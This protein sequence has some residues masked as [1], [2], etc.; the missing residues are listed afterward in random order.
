MGFNYK[1]HRERFNPERVDKL[2]AG[3]WM[4]ISD[5]INYTGFSD[6]TLRKHAFIGKLE[7]VVYRKFL[8][9]KVNGK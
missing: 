9:V 1:W 7:A 3:L 6:T 8:H 5:A 4:C 2:P